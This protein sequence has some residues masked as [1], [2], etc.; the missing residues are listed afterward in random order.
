MYVFLN[1]TTSSQ[2]RRNFSPEE[3]EK[4]FHGNFGQKLLPSPEPNAAEQTFGVLPPEDGI[5]GFGLEESGEEREEG[6]G[7]G[8]DGGV[9]LEDDDDTQ[10]AT[11]LITDKGTELK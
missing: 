5:L 9:T 4:L 10:A 6:S 11:Q 1:P 3:E 8:R 2:F 7:G